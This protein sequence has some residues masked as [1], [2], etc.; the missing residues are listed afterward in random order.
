M[1][2]LINYMRRIV[3]QLI[4]LNFFLQVDN[5]LYSRAEMDFM[6]TFGN[7]IEYFALSGTLEYYKRPSTRMIRYWS[8]NNIKHVGFR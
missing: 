3:S 8:I 6:F 7:T 4:I 5:N 1:V 2:V